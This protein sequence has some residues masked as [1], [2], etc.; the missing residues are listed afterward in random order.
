MTLGEKIQK[1]RQ[2][3]N[4]TQKELADKLGI[5]TGIIAVWE[6]DETTP[7]VDNRFPYC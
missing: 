5:T 4:L 7:S 3:R 2:E 6:S 1:L